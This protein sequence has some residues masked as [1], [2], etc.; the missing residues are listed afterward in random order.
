M[1][2]HALASPVVRA[3]AQR[4]TRSWVLRRRLPHPF[5]QSRIYVSP[6]AGLR[7]L[8]RPLRSADPRLLSLVEEFVFRGAVA[9]DIG[10]NVGLFSFA[11]ANAAGSR[12]AVVAAEPDVWLVQLLRRSANS[13]PVSVAPVTVVPAAL[14]STIA[15]RKFWLTRRGRADNYLDGYGVTQTGDVL[16]DQSIVCVT[17]DWLLDQLP[18][19]DLLKIDVEGAEVEVFQGACRFFER[20]HPI[21]ICEVRYASQVPVTEFLQARGYTIYDGEQPAAERRPM[22]RAP[23]CTLAIPP[24]LTRSHE[25]SHPVHS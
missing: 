10:A 14:G 4:L 17:L 20:A 19:P 2:N 9:W 1:T 25:P 7:Y 5:R 13:Q 21:V 6:S 15:L 3:I 18:P 11:A 24:D 22:D 16:E 23:W 12:G 8:F